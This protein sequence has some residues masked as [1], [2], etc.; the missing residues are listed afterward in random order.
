MHR[1]KNTHRD[2][3]RQGDC[4]HAARVRRLRQYPFAKVCVCVFHYDT[5]LFPALVLNSVPDMVLEDVTELY[6]DP[7]V[8]LTGFFRRPLLR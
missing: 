1:L 7:L 4:R 6:V 3:D 5:A 2:E 8:Y